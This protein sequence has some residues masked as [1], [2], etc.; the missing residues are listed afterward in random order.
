MTWITQRSPVDELLVANKAAGLR[1]PIRHAPSIVELGCQTHSPEAAGDT[2]PVARSGRR[3]LG[4]AVGQP[5]PQEGEGRWAALGV[6]IRRGLCWHCVLTAHRLQRDPPFTVG[7]AS[8]AANWPYAA[9]LSKLLRNSDTLHRQMGEALDAFPIADHALWVSTSC[10]V[11][12]AL[13]TR[14]AC[15]GGSK[16]IVRAVAPITALAG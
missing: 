11:V 5:N 15:G 14:R 3:P 7:W 9:F 6:H 8:S 16:A 2:S 10:P 13:G 4:L 12:S 1:L